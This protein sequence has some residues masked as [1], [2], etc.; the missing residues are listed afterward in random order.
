MEEK[1]LL[2]ML[3]LGTMRDEARDEITRTR[4]NSNRRRNRQGGEG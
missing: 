1:K 3:F 4:S 2:Y